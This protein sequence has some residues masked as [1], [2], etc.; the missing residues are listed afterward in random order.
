MNSLADIE[1]DGQ[2]KKIQR[3]KAGKLRRL[4][5]NRSILLYMHFYMDLTSQAVEWSEFS[6]R[7]NALL[8]EQIV[9]KNGFTSVLE[10]MKFDDGIHMNTFLEE[11]NCKLQNGTIYGK[12]EPRKCTENLYYEATEVTWKDD[13]ELESMVAKGNEDDAELN[14]KSTIDDHDY[15]GED[16]RQGTELQEIEEQGEDEGSPGKGNQGKKW[17]KLTSMKVVEIREEILSTLLERVESYFPEESLDSFTILDNKYFPTDNNEL[18]HYGEIEVRNVANALGYRGQVIEDIVDGWK[19]LMEI[20][21]QQRWLC[22][23]NQREEDPN[24][25]WTYI[26][27]NYGTVLGEPVKRF[28]RHVLVIPAS[29]GTQFN[30]LKSYHKIYK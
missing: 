19:D 21:Y 30:A 11:I 24:Q 5:T 27:Q 2:F 10:G 9:F 29:S 14:A 1:T 6:Q 3:D 7:R 12:N 22:N 17:P 28:I 16:D 8:I 15:D 26:L 23:P 13:I 20:F 4:V 25:F 18:P